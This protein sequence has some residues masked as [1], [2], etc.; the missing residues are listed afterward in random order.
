MMF[1]SYPYDYWHKIRHFDQY[2]VFLAFDFRLVLLPRV[3][4]EAC[5]ILV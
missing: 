4:Y 5:V 2:S 1:T 3:T